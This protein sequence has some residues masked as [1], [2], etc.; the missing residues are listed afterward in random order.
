M[1]GNNGKVTFID[2]RDIIPD[3]T[4]YATEEYVDTAIEN[5]N[6]D[7]YATKQY[8]NTAITNINIDQYATEDYVNTAIE[9]IDLDDYATK[10]YVD[11]QLEDVPTN[12]IL[13]GKLLELKEDI[14][15][16]VEYL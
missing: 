12:S 2:Q 10:Q 11:N 4:G 5:I 13:D 7:N 16:S 1:V 9:N 15:N 14:L 8:V 3:L 6:L